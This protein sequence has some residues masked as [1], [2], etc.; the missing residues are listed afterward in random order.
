MLN[1]LS[2]PIM[3]ASFAA[4]AGVIWIAGMKLA[5]TTDI[6]SSRLHVGV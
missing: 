3:L 4:C 6:L 2:L 1:G 5:D